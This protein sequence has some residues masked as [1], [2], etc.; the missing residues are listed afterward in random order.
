M[1]NLIIGFI[2]GLFVANYGVVAIA[3]EVDHLINTAK[4]VQVKIDTQ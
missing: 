2:L 4:T 1:I 3:K